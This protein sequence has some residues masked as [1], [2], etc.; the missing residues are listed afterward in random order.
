MNKKELIK[1][2]G[3][4]KFNISKENTLKKMKKNLINTILHYKS[5]DIIKKLYGNK[6]INFM[7]Q[8]DLDENDNDWFPNINKNDLTEKH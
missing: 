3:I 2:Y 1:K 4:K 5:D 7:I 8:E 6:I